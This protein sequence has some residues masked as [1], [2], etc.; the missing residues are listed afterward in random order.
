MSTVQCK[1]SCHVINGR[2][3]QD[4]AY[5]G[6]TEQHTYNVIYDGHGN[7]DCINIIQRIH[8]DDPSDVISHANPVQEMYNRTLTSVG[9]STMNLFRVNI[10]STLI[11]NFSIGD[12]SSWIWNITDNK[13]PSLVMVNKKHIPTDT[14]EMGRLHALRFNVPPI[15]T[16]VRSSPVKKMVVRSENTIEQ[17]NVYNQIVD[18][19][20]LDHSVRGL[21][22]TQAL[23]HLGVTQCDGF[24]YRY[25]T[26]KGCTYL[27][28]AVSDGVT[29][30]VTLDMI[31]NLII[32]GLM[33]LPVR[34]CRL[35]KNQ[36]MR[37][38]EI[39]IRGSSFPIVSRFP[40]TEW[41]DISACVNL[42]LA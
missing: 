11:E 31:R 3:S 2:K 26:V 19:Q 33:D 23:G 39:A 5:T 4:R 16:K 10:G 30:V 41:D 40:S 38:W 18:F 29:D 37:Q 6:R 13:N 34:L 22:M 42:V 12:S 36:W 32:D 21:A 35:A 17:L 25:T 14:D 7:S 28:M 9:G 8:S 1:T 27:C 20:T 15:L 24:Q